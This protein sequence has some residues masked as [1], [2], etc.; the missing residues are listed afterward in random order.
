MND[1]VTI[2]QSAS[3]MGISRRQMLRKV[4]ENNIQ[5]HKKPGDKKTYLRKCDISEKCHTSNIG[6]GWYGGKLS[7]LSWL[8]PLLP[9]DCHHYIEPFGG[10][11]AVLLNRE[12]AKIETYNDLDGELVNFFRVLREKPKELQRQLSL[13]PYSREEYEIAITRDPEISKMELARRFFVKVRMSIMGLAQSASK[14]RCQHIVKSKPCVSKWWNSIEELNLIAARVMHVQIENLRG[15][16]L[17]RKYD[18]EDAFF[19]IDPPYIHESRVAT[20]RNEY[21]YEMNSDEHLELSNILRNIKGRFALSGY[22]CEF[23]DTNYDWCYRADSRDKRCSSGKSSRV[24]SLWSNYD[25]SVLSGQ[26]KFW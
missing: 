23:M 7:H 5:K 1:L 2:D 6:F 4:K 14:G 15:L 13:T 26:C 24:E 19:Y 17:I 10:S 12:S 20:C 9:T 3:L 8:L 21:F 18:F 11:M 22:R 25:T 16:E